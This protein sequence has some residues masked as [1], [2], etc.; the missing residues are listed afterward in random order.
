MF[1]TRMIFIS[2]YYCVY[3]TSIVV[4]I[5][6]GFPFRVQ[7]TWSIN[8]FVPWNPSRIL[9]QSTLSGSV[10]VALNLLLTKVSTWLSGILVV[11]RGIHMALPRSRF[12]YVSDNKSGARWTITL[13]SMHAL[14]FGVYTCLHDTCAFFHAEMSPPHKQSHIQ[15]HRMLSGGRLLSWHRSFGRDWLFS[16][17]ISSTICFGFWFRLCNIC[18][19]ES[20]LFD[21]R[22]EQSRSFRI[23]VSPHLRIALTV[24]PF[25]P[26]FAFARIWQ[27]SRPTVAY[28]Y[29]QYNR[30]VD[31]YAHFDSRMH[32]HKACVLLGPQQLWRS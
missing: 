3:V 19:V 23:F 30:L 4:A 11:S 29:V 7:W 22:I 13:R 8:F 31:I 17:I 10:L 24:R 21:T 16:D 27:Q 25:L 14:L 5:P 6:A 28:R 26:W 12:S 1:T 2:F 20:V 15:T 18:L 32:T 9:N